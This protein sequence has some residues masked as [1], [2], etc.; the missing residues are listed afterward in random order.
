[1]EGLACL[2]NIRGLCRNLDRG[3]MFSTELFLSRGGLRLLRCSGMPHPS[4]RE[5][6]R[7]GVQ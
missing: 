4:D 1:V 3:R 6:L 7:T 5:V 2:K